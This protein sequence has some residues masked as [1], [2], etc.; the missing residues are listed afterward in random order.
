[1]VF[2][3]WKRKNIIKNKKK[4]KSEKKLIRTNKINKKIK[5]K[6]LNKL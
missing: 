5:Q 3:K 6:E 1:M 4:T 2:L